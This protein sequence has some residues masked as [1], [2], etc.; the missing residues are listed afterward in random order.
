MKVEFDFDGKNYFIDVEVEQFA[1]CYTYTLFNK[2]L[3]RMFID[4]YGDLTILQCIFEF[5]LIGY[6]ELKYRWHKKYKIDDIEKKTFYTIWYF[7][8]VSYDDK[9]REI[10]HA[11]KEAEYGESPDD[12]IQEI[13]SSFPVSALDKFQ[14][15]NKIASLG[16]YFETEQ[17]AIN[18]LKRLNEKAASLNNESV[19]DSKN[20]K[21][22]LDQR[23]LCKKH[24]YD[25]DKL[26]DDYMAYD[27][28]DNVEREKLGCYTISIFSI[29]D[30]VRMHYWTY[31]DS[32]SFPND[33]PTF[34]V[35]P[36]LASEFCE[37][38][39]PDYLTPG[40]TTM[41][42]Y[43]PCFFATKE[44][45]EQACDEI[46]ALFMENFNKMMEKDHYLKEA[47]ERLQA[48]KK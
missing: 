2:R 37:Y 44:E 36:E 13:L 40:Y 43:H 12:E 34:I 47:Y 24:G 42:P 8:S 1:D 22:I 14:M 18:F 48:A 17:E 31:Y 26:I 11:V 9:G 45:A 20:S 4:K 46:R 5:K 10:S 41:D 28:L 15:D 30:N 35:I 27:K 32:F 33:G 38:I 6:D 16:N 39:D 3:M 29:Y 25:Y 7:G 19:F 21:F 23:Q